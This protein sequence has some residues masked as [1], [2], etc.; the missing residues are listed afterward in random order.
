[1]G[2]TLGIE[3]GV[4]MKGERM[5]IPHKLRADMKEH[6]HSA[7]LGYESVNMCELIVMICR[8]ET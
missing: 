2:D 1:M 6:L 3:E 4:L 7:H 8:R 5:I